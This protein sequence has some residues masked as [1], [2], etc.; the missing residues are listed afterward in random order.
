MSKG[1][2]VYF[3]PRPSQGWTGGDAIDIATQ[4]RTL[5]ARIKRNEARNYSVSDRL[6]EIADELFSF[7]TEVSNLDDKEREFDEDADDAAQRADN[8]IKEVV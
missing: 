8:E 6:A 3:T 4:L 1:E 2:G 7:A 5:S